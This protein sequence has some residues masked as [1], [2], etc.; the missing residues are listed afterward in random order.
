M[1]SRLA[2]IHP[3]AIIHP[4][5]QIGSFAT[6]E[7]DVIIDN[8]SRIGTN[9]IIMS[10]SRIGKDCNIFPGAIIGSQPQDLKYNNEVT[11]LYIGNNTTIREYATVN[12]GT[13]SK[14]RTI[15]GNN[16]LIMAY[17]H[18]SH[19]CYIGITLS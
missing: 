10:G 5:V 14:G 1:I 7:D 6:I 8:D 3:E 16:V 18:V 2:D 11:E 17:A 12:K 15:I 4:S 19:D 9:T 13:L